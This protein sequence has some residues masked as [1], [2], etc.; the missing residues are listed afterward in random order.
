M[1][2]GAASLAS[3]VKPDGK[4]A[5]SYRFITEDDPVEV[6]NTAFD[7]FRIIKIR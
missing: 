2:G 5:F 7:N 1:G 3:L 6:F 4:V